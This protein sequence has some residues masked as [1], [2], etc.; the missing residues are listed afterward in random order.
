MLCI[1][2][3]GL[4]GRNKMGFFSKWWKGTK[5]YSGGQKGSLVAQL[6]ITVF[7]TIGCFL[8]AW[9]IK[10]SGGYSSVSFLLFCFGT[11]QLISL[12]SMLKQ[13]K[14]INDMEQLMKNNN[15]NIQVVTE[16]KKNG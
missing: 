16:E 4:G 11:L 8:G 12:R 7:I 14:L 3:L 6:W 10:A 13:Y 2:Y 9:Q 1:L 5:E 15:I